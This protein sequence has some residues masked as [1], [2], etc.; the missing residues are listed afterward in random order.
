MTENEVASTPAVGPRLRSE[1]W[2]HAFVAALMMLFFL[3]DVINVVLLHA[4][5]GGAVPMVS[6]L[7]EALILAFIAIYASGNLKNLR[8]QPGSL[9][10]ALLL[11]ATFALYTAIGLIKFPTIG[12][13]F[14]LRTLVMPILLMLVG[15]MYGNAIR[16][17]TA[18]AE[19]LV[20][21]YLALCV[22]VAISALFD[23]IFLSD[24]FWTA[25]NL[26]EL[27]RVKGYEGVAVGA[28]PDNMYS[29]YFGRRAFGLAFNPLNLAYVLIP[30][31][32][33]AWCRRRWL[34][35]ALLAAAMILSWSRQPIVA[36]A[37]VLAASLFAPSVLFALGLFALPIVGWYAGIFY[38]ELVNDPSAAGHFETVATGL[39]GIVAS[40][41]G[42]GIG[43]AGIFAG[44]Y[45]SLSGESA[46][47]NIANQIGLPGLALYL[48]VLAVGMRRAGP[49]GREL[50]LVGAIYAITAFLSPHV[51]T[52]KSTFAFFLFLGMNL[53]LSQVPAHV[54]GAH[55]TRSGL[56]FATAPA[57]PPR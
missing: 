20:R 55:D 8:F 41:L 21:L 31:V 6:A 29:F 13:A 18:L 14:E 33:V 3:Q 46:I 23:Y 39:G 22:V 19:R 52:I 5:L 25:V 35:F 38:R 57:E 11:A 17:H 2:V 15:W 50:R 28:L 40:P 16:H 42:Y 37:V 24:E 34:L 30:G 27:E 26:G 49:L 45:S 51:F 1:I 43:A 56:G 10:L 53:A 47:L 7:K 48:V 54:R 12:V 36:T 4:G 32:V 9:V 44:A